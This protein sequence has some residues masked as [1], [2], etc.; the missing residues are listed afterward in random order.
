MRHEA[1]QHSFCA[2]LELCIV[3]EMRA[4]EGLQRDVVFRVAI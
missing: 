1:F 2:W 4:V 3:Y